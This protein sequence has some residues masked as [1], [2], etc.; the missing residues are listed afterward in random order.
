MKFEAF[1]ADTRRTEHLMDHTPSTNM[2][3]EPGATTLATIRQHLAAD[4]Q[5]C[6]ARMIEVHGE[7]AVIEMWPSLQVPAMTRW[8]A[9]SA[10][11][12]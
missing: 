10:P 1:S 5:L 11:S 3:P 6:L 4:E 8:I 9:L 12:A 7:A 2:Y